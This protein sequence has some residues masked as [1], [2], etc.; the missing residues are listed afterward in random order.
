[1]LEETASKHGVPGMA[2]IVVRRDAVV[3]DATFGIRRIG[4]SERIAPSDCFHIGS[5]TKAMTAT[6]AAILVEKGKLAWDTKLVDVFPEW[7]NEIHPDYQRITL[8]DLLL[9]R[10]GVPEYSNFSYLFSNDPTHREDGSTNHLS[11]DKADWREMT[12]LQGSPMEQRRQF[13]LQVLRRPPAVLPETAFLYSNAGYGIA[14]AMM[15]RVMNESWESLMNTYLFE[16]LGIRATFDWPATDDPH[17]PWGHFAAK[18]GMQPHDPHDS[19]HLPAC[20][21]PAG[22]I[23]MSLED[24]AKFLQL[25]LKGLEG[26]DGLLRAK[27]IKYLHTDPH[28]TM[29]N[30]AAFAF[31]WGLVNYDG[32][33]SSWAY[34]SAG[35]FLSGA[36]I[37]PSH[38]LAV[39]VFANAGV[40]RAGDAG[41]ET[42]QWSLR[43]Y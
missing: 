4:F 7:K 34:G 15:E 3:E 25:H 10:A 26:F 8:T 42:L 18:S 36:A 22:G 37:S 31:G 13:A 38:D 20:L 12:S 33:P 17:Q 23:S 29:M 43:H 28:D 9:C 21:A 27:T 41:V 24:F 1:M 19:Y 39:A 5:N 14:G 35:T 30:G 32:K 11:Q 2:A 40:I 16:P 6:L